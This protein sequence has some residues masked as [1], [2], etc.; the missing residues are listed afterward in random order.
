MGSALGLHEKQWEYTTK[1]LGHA[2]ATHDNTGERYSQLIEPRFVA[3]N[4]KSDSFEIMD[5]QTREILYPYGYTTE[6]G[7][8]MVEKI[9]QDSSEEEAIEGIGSGIAL[10]KE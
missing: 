5:F 9:L 2:K 1:I 10:L 6:D 3:Y 8:A 7:Q 4:E